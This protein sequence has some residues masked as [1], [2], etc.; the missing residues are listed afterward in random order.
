MNPA[1]TTQA[2]GASR[3][4]GIGAWLALVAV[5]LAAAAAGAVGLFGSRSD[6]VSYTVARLERGLVAKRVDAN[7]TVVARDTVQV[8][9]EISG[10][11]TRIV[12]DFNAIVASGDLLAE[13]ASDIYRTRVAEAEAELQLGRAQL[14]VARSKAE[15]S[16]AE[17]LASR[18]RLES[19]DAERAV[20]E[21][22]LAFARAEFQRRTAP[23]REAFVAAAERDRA[24]ADLD[25]TTA[26]LQSADAQRRAAEAG[27]AASAAAILT[28]QAEVG[29]AEATLLQ[30][31]AALD[32]ARLDLARTEIRA[33]MSGVV[34]ERNIEVGQTVAASLQSPILF[35]I[36][37]DIDEMLIELFV[38]EAD[39]GV[40]REGQKV[41]FRVAAFPGR[42]FNGAIAQLRLAPMLIQNVVTYVAMLSVPNADRLL[43]PGMTATVRVDVEERADVPRLPN[44]ALR[45]RPQREERV[46]KLPGRRPGG[47][48]G[49]VHVEAGDGLREVAV[50]LGLVDDR[51]TEIRGGLPPGAAVVTGYR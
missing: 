1:R 22:A 49:V 32:R 2:A 33:P 36:A 45:F 31:Q 35:T 50:D 24:R 21:A 11:V 48:T 3:R 46:E 40:L 51:Y 47:R 34:I 15:Q 43:R 26:Q 25:R 44:A 8:G 14:D 23:G 38:D 42:T 10:R 17:Q 28:A 13:L 37:R 7:G 27:A 12:V 29:V 16:K 39:V 19:A 5:L 4:R 18:M 30:R 6:S 20:A 9:T 41:E